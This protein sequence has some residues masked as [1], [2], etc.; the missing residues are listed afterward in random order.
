M[1]AEKRKTEAVQTNRLITLVSED[2]LKRIEEY[3]RGL[4]PIPSQA[5][6]VRQLI[7]KGL[8]ATK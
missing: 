5:E 8:S 1:S 4:T 3:R 2:L 6:A 7:E